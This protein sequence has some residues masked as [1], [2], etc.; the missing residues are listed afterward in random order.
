[1]NPGK[2][3]SKKTLKML[4][5][6]ISAILIATVSAAVYYSLGVTS[7]IQTA[8]TDV[9]FKV[10][11]DNGTDCNVQLSPDN[12]TAV[13]TGLKAYP[14]AS[15]T[16]IDPVRVVNNGT[17][18]HL[19]R[20]RHGSISGTGEGNFSYVKFILRNGTT[21]DNA[22]LVT[23]TYTWNTTSNDWNIPSAT[24]WKSISNANPDTEWSITIETKA[25]DNAQSASVTIEIKVDVQ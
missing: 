1:M 23:L 12:T 11:S 6:L 4:G 19:V 18:A 24:D 16:Y 17:I 8:T 25:I 15:Y 20:L 13:I 7:T 14:N 5:L 9:W 22:T 3:R 2:I 10:G 21:E